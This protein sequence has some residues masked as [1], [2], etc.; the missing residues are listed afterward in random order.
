MKTG[1]LYQ[2]CSYLASAD[3]LRK[4]PYR[5]VAQ[6]W[7]KGLNSPKYDLILGTRKDRDL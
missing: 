7:S 5:G 6:A 1:Q 2:K 3:I 4:K